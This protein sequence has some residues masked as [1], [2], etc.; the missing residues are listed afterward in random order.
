MAFVKHYFGQR[1]IFFGPRDE[2]GCNF[3]LRGGVVAGMMIMG[4]GGGCTVA[5]IRRARQ[6]RWR[7]Y[8]GY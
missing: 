3:G 2:A 5:R 6:W 8:D 1:A 4:L 7:D